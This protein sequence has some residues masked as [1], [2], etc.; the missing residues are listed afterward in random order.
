[1]QPVRVGHDC[2]QLEGELAEVLRPP[3]Q[4]LIGT[5]TDPL[6][7]QAGE[8]EVLGR[9]DSEPVGL[10]RP[11]AIPQLR[12]AQKSAEPR[13]AGG[14]TRA[15][16]VP[17][18]ATRDASAEPSGHSTRQRANQLQR[19]GADAGQVPLFGDV[20][21]RLAPPRRVGEALQRNARHLRGSRALASARDFNGASSRRR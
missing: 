15:Q 7:Q 13:S 4:E 2:Q 21:A 19:G 1:M 16:H 12:C 6:R 3:R 8:L 5:A 10:R 20:V 9:E 11:G 18:L 17:T 14:E